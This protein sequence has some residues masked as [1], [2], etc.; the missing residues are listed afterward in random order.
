MTAIGARKKKKT[1]TTMIK[2]LLTAAFFL[3]ACAPA[4]SPAQ[5]QAQSP[6]GSLFAAETDRQWRL[7]ERLR[8]ISGLALS[9]DGRLFAHD[10]EQAVIYE[11]DTREGRIVKAFALG[12]AEIVRGDF[13]GLAITPNGD[14]WMTTSQGRLYRFREAADGARTRFERFDTGLRDVC[15]IEGLAH[16]AAEESLILA[17]KQNQTRSMRDTVSLHAWRIGANQAASPWRQWPVAALATAAGVEN[18][19]PSSLDIDASTGRLLLLS[20]RN[21][22]LAEIDGET[23]TSARALGRQHTQAEGVV[24]LADGSLAISDEGG[25]GLALLSIYPRTAP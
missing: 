24:S 23:I 2:R 13:E 7:P 1:M 8:E 6:P 4:N 14:F 9:P 22:A 18:F 5:A 16:L 11:L 3:C 12:D 10:D 25:D 21:A 17:C 15:E 20:A 19:R